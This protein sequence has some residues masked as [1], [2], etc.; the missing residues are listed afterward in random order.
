MGQ[1]SVVKEQDTNGDGVID[2]HDG[3]SLYLSHTDSQDKNRVNVLISTKP[4]TA[5][6]VPRRSNSAD[7]CEEQGCWDYN[8]EG[9]VELI[10]KA[11]RDVTSASEGKVEISVG[12]AT[13]VK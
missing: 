8:D 12:C 11:C 10:G 1:I 4:G 2:W 6:T 13:V 9:Q 3:S 7:P 5:T